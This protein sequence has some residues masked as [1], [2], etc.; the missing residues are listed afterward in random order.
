MSVPNDTADWTEFNS[1]LSRKTAAVLTDWS[2]RYAAGAISK[3]EFYILITGLYDTTS[4]L[5]A[6]DLSFLI[7]DVHTELRKAS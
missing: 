1:E 7:A 6:R 2:N 4:G 5:I 3:R